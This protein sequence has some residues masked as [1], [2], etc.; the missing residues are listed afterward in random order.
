LGT[1]LTAVVIS[2]DE[3]ANAIFEPAIV[4]E[5]SIAEDEETNA[6]VITEAVTVTAREFIYALATIPPT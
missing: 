3:L 2:I 1:A 5:D 4:D 6:T